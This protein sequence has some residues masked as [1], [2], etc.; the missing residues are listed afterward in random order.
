MT[1]YKRNPQL[2]SINTLKFCFFLAAKKSL[3]LFHNSHDIFVHNLV[4]IC[5]LS[6]RL[7]SS[8]GVMANVLKCVF[9]VNEFKLQLWYHAHFLNNTF[10]KNMNLFLYPTAVK[11]SNLNNVFFNY[12]LASQC[13][14]RY[15]HLLKVGVYKKQKKGDD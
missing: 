14:F 3:C 10:W 5:I 2:S 13:C 11:N 12:F 9:E 1:E 7:V 6:V 4:Y 8:Y 15:V